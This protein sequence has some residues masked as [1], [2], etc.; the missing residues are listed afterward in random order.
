M[1]SITNR[2]L[3]KDHYWTDSHARSRVAGTTGRVV[4]AATNHVKT[5]V[6]RSPGLGTGR[7]GNRRTPGRTDGRMKERNRTDAAHAARRNHVD[8]C[9]LRIRLSE[10][11]RVVHPPPYA[12]PSTCLLMQDNAD[13]SG[14]PRDDSLLRRNFETM[15]TW[16]KSHGPRL[17]NLNLQLCNARLFHFIFLKEFN[18]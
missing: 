12:A 1:G 8:A 5:R 14:C 16:E 6:K 2:V 11:F 3:G 17:S 13:Y 7:R 18:F 15:I 9:R 10:L 4:H